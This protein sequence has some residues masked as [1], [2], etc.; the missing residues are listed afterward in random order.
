MSGIYNGSKEQFWSIMDRLCTSMSQGTYG[1]KLSGSDMIMGFILPDLDVEFSYV[2]ESGKIW[3]DREGVEDA[4]FVFQMSA[5]TIHEIL[6][7]KTNP[8]IA[9][10]AKKIEVARVDDQEAMNRSISVL[11]LMCQAYKKILASLE[12]PCESD[13]MAMEEGEEERGTKGGYCGL[14]Q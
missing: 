4:D 12:A 3:V 10:A 1:P 7:R 2:I 14:E 13:T 8:M 11:G 6:A 5:N 9:L